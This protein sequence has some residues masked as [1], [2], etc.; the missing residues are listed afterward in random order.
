[1]NRIGS[2]GKKYNSSIYFLDI[3]LLGIYIRSRSDYD[4]TRYHM[5]GYTKKDIAERGK[6]KPRQVQ[7]YTE[8]G[9]VEPDEAKGKGTG[10]VRRYSRRN[11]I[12]FLI[13]RELLRHGMTIAN[14]KMI[15]STLRDSEATAKYGDGRPYDILANSKYLLISE[16]QNGEKALLNLISKKVEISK[17]SMEFF[18]DE[19]SSLSCIFLDLERIL[20]EADRD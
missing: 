20:F 13:I 10:N 18:L 4:Y 6:L 19:N 17:K 1:M 16:D 3:A 5:A 15:L 9:A 7:F 8:Q 12:D 14:I 11:L 2:G